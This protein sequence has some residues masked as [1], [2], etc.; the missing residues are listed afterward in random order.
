MIQRFRT[1]SAILIT[2][3][4]AAPIAAA[5][6]TPAAP[7]APAAPARGPA[8][9]PV[10]CGPGVTGKNVASDSRCFELRTYTVRAEGPGS[11]DLLH[12]RFRDHTN[13]LFRKHGMEI[14]G[15]WQ[16]NNPGM[17]RTLIYVLAYKD[18]AARDA[19]WK[20]FQS[21]PEWVKV[22]TDLQ[23]GTQVEAVFMNSTDYGPMK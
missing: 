2:G 17:E 5:A 1:F 7:G 14:V 16:P 13:R 9:P 6:Q 15:F 18:R 12:T 19:A 23:V 4:L 3:V 21:D 11:I 20:A 10:P 8:G 22:R